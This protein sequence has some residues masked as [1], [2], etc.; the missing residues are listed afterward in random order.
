MRPLVAHC[1]FGL[2]QLYQRTG[3][4]AEANKQIR[5]AAVMYHELG[6]DHWQERAAA[7]LD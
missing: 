2:G 1:H 7:P 3:Q 6:M 5:S 4:H